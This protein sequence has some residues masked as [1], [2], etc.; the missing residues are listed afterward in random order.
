MGRVRSN[1]RD[2]RILKAS[3][4]RKGYMRLRVTLDGV[5]HSYKV[6]RLV[7]M[8]FVP[9]PEDKPQVNHIDGNKNN[10]SADNLEW[11]TNREN[12]RHAIDTGL[13]DS[14][15]A[16]SLAENERRKK[17][18]IATNIVTGEVKHY[19]S[20]AE[21]ERELKTRHITSVLKGKR[22]KAAGHTFSY[23]EGGDA[24]ARTENRKS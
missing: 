20:I 24:C 1:L 9:N 14:V 11:V 21:A 18:I 7:A 13:F 16:G 19:D 4:D 12:A 22:S 10:N 17:K 15:I 8:A 5:K 2:G 23:A 6:H 3:P